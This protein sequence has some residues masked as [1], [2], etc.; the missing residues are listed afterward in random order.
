MR[1]SP[2]SESTHIVF[3]CQSLTPFRI[4]RGPTCLQPAHQVQLEGGSEHLAEKS[5]KK[6]LWQIFDACPSWVAK[7]SLS[8]LQWAIPTPGQL[9]ALVP[10]FGAQSGS[11]TQSLPNMQAAWVIFDS[12][13]VSFSGT[14]ETL[15]PSHWGFYQA[16]PVLDT[17]CSTLNREHSQ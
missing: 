2:L 9:S 6:A 1:G 13:P 16:N 15:V 8:V 11:K 4:R 17:W 10:G 7:K 14:R 12:F 3:R 5:D